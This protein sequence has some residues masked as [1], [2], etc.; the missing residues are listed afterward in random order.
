MLAALLHILQYDVMPL[1]LEARLWNSV[2]GLLSLQAQQTLKIKS[3]SGI[4]DL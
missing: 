3:E 4:D 2:D 1:G